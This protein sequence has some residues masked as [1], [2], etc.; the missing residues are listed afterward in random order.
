[1]RGTHRRSPPGSRH[2]ISAYWRAGA[3]RSH[4]HEHFCR[5]RGAPTPIEGLIRERGWICGLS[6]RGQ[7]NAPGAPRSTARCRLGAVRLRA[8]SGEPHRPSFRF[9]RRVGRGRRGR[10]AAPPDAAWRCSPGPSHLVFLAE[11]CCAAPGCARP[12]ARPGGTSTCRWT[13]AARTRGAPGWAAVARRSARA[14]H[15]PHEIATSGV[16]AQ[17][18]RSGRITIDTAAGD[19]PTRAAETM[20]GLRMA[21]IRAALIPARRDRQPRPPA[22][23]LHPTMRRSTRRSIGRLRP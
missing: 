5:S 15:R 1:M 12:I 16:V 23:K 8:S 4:T 22:A 2:R 21:G 6:L 13:A 7:L 17:A 18:G 20:S 3:Q 10:G 19:A 11:R 9:W 14:R